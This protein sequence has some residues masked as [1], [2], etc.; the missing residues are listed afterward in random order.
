MQNEIPSDIAFI[1]GQESQ[2]VQGTDIDMDKHLTEVR[3]TLTRL[4]D[5]LLNHSITPKQYRRWHFK[6][7]S[8]EHNQVYDELRAELDL[9]ESNSLS[10]EE[11]SDMTVRASIQ[12]QG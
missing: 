6:C 4:K 11:V 1:L 12:V 9:L 5:A 10:D 7:A 3:D 2:K 8:A